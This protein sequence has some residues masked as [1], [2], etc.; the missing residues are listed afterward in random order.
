MHVIRILLQVKFKDDSSISFLIFHQV[1]RRQS[2]FF[3]DILSRSMSEISTKKAN[4]S[5]LST[6]IFDKMSSVKMKSHSRL[7]SKP[8]RSSR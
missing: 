5:T 2:S 3:V 4:D 8:Q 6:A 1:P 7:Q